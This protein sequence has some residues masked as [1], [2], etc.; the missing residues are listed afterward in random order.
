MLLNILESYEVQGSAVRSQPGWRDDSGTIQ[1]V[2]FEWDSD[3][4]HHF[5]GT[6]DFFIPGTFVAQKM[7]VYIAD[8]QCCYP[9]G[10]GRF[11]HSMLHKV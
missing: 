11:G 5:T 2:Q 10:Y 7:K 9:E 4:S 1:T 8:G 3:S 6:K